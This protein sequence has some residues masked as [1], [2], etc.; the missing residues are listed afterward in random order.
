MDEGNNGRYL[1]GLQRYCAQGYLLD[2]R[3]PGGQF[4]VKTR[5]ITQGQQDRSYSDA[6]YPTPLAISSFEM[7]LGDGSGGDLPLRAGSPGRARLNVASSCEVRFEGHVT[8]RSGFDRPVG[9]VVTSFVTYELVLQQ[10]FNCLTVFD[11]L[12]D[13]RVTS[14]DKQNISSVLHLI[15]EQ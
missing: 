5:S 4:D 12:R 10:F 11:G 13:T 1:R 6:L 14:Y 3:Y 8:C 9:D 15:L 7:T 2:P